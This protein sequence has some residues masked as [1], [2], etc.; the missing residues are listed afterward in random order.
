MKKFYIIGLLLMV[1]VVFVACGKAETNEEGT[2]AIETTTTVE[3]VQTEEA[4]A[5]ETPAEEA[6]VETPAA[7]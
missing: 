6:P 1:M 3:E 5:V 4:P 7:E 2:E